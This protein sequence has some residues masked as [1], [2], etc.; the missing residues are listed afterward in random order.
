MSTALDPLVL[1]KTAGAGMILH[2]ACSV[3][4]HSRIAPDDALFD[5]LFASPLLAEVNTRRW[6]LKGKYFLPWVGAPDD[7]G[8]S[9][10]ISQILFWGARLGA[11]L[12]IVGFGAFLFTVFWQI[13]HR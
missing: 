13:G 6:Y 4:L 2:Y 1:F 11:M 7:L 8:S 12:L 5:K 10:S 3:L 9:G